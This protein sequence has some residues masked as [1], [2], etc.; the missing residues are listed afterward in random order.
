MLELRNLGLPFL[1]ELHVVQVAKAGCSPQSKAPKFGYWIRQKIKPHV[2]DRWK[3]HEKVRL[4]LACTTR[5]QDAVPTVGAILFAR[6]RSHIQ[7]VLNSGLLI[8]LY[9][10]SA[11]LCLC[12][13]L[14]LGF[15][16]NHNRY[17]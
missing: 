5:H 7:T 4:G 1:L 17:L 2:Y 15:I 16:K 13:W 6:P 8:T 12:F 11:S 9:F 14:P 10:W 3:V